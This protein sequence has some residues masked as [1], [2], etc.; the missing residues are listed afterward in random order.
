MDGVVSNGKGT[1]FYG[2]FLAELYRNERNCGCFETWKCQFLHKSL[3]GS[4]FVLFFYDCKNRETVK[5]VQHKVLLLFSYCMELKTSKLSV[6]TES[7]ITVSEEKN[8]EEDY[9]DT[10]VFLV[11]M[12]H[13]YRPHRAHV[14]ITYTLNTF[15][16]GAG[17]ETLLHYNLSVRNLISLGR[18]LRFM[19][20]IHGKVF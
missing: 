19:C 18:L 12:S 2:R 8:C 10:A 9:R 5:T 4:F 16:R 17:A 3:V 15:H 1:S 6:E 13:L 14:A 7:H 11:E 20:H